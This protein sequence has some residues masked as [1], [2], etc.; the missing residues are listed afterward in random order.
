MNAES[1]KDHYDESKKSKLF[2]KEDYLSE[3]FREGMK[4][5]EKY[6]ENFKRSKNTKNKSS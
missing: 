6:Y 1:R 3:A 4:L 5:A 2:H